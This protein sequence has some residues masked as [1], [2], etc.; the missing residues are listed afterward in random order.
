M[1]FHFFTKYKQELDCK[2][3]LLQAEQ[4]Y[5][6]KLELWMK[7]WIK[8][9]KKEATD[10]EDIRSIKKIYDDASKS[11]IYER[12][13]TILQ[14]KEDKSME[15]NQFYDLILMLSQ[16]EK[17]EN[18][19]AKGIIEIFL[20]GQI[21]AI[22]Q[23]F[24]LKD[25]LEKESTYMHL[26]E[27]EL[28]ETEEQFLQKKEPGAESKK[29]LSFFDAIKK[30][31]ILVKEE[32]VYFKQRIIQGVRIEGNKILLKGDHFTALQNAQWIQGDTYVKPSMKD[33]YSYFVERGQFNNWKQKDIQFTLGISN[34]EAKVSLEIEIYPEQLYIKYIPN[35]PLRFAI[36]QLI[37]EQVKKVL[38]KAQRIAA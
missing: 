33:P 24:A 7:I 28:K 10:F 6:K 25:I 20:K 37:P 19:L 8:L 11:S 2:E 32:K 29:Y 12:L 15:L 1:F 18:A 38:S 30:D 17:E 16:K 35:T 36:A 9:S 3:L 14:K 22:E 34:A 27:K 4:I 23:F 21:P 31:I 26:E 5:S 13:R